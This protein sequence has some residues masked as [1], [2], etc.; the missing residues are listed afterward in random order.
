MNVNNGKYSW[1]ETPGE[2][3]K[4]MKYLLVAL[5]PFAMITYT[6]QYVRLVIQLFLTGK[7]SFS[8]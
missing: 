2:L 3:S 4:E 5:Y 7:T 6:E 8:R 1:K